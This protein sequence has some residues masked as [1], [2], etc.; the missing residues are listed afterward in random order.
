[1]GDECPEIEWQDPPVRV[2][3]MVEFWK[4]KGDNELVRF[5][6]YFDT[7]GTLQGYLLGTIQ[8][9][10]QTGEL[11]GNEFVWCVSPKWRNTRAP[12]ALL[13]AFETECKAAGC[14]MVQFGFSMEL[15]PNKMAQMYDR[16]GYRKAFTIVRK[17][18]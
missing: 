10:P 5:F 14:T 13:R 16:L 4:D 11:Y 8:P 18:I 2:E 15:S 7:T 9:D 17:N 3:P 6:G 1:M 12:L